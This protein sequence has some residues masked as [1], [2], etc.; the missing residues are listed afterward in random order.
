MA[1]V[2]CANNPTGTGVHREQTEKEEGRKP[3]VGVDYYKIKLDFKKKKLFSVP[4]YSV[5]SAV[6]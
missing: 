2:F 5:N 3:K 1:S 6:L 4:L